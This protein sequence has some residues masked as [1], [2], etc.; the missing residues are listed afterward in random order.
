MKDESAKFWCRIV[1]AIPFAPL[2]AGVIAACCAQSLVVGLLSLI[3]GILGGI[4]ITLFGILVI[5]ADRRGSRQ[6]AP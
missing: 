6:N 5:V 2:I 3:S 4:W 1:I